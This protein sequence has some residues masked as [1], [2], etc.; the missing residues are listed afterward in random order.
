MMYETYANKKLVELTALNIEKAF[1]QERYPGMTMPLRYETHDIQNLSIELYYD[2]ELD[3]THVRLAHRETPCDYITYAMLKQKAFKFV[4]ASIKGYYPQNKAFIFRDSHLQAA[5]VGLIRAFECMSNDI[6][7][8]ENM[9][10]LIRENYEKMHQL[11]WMHDI[12]DKSKDMW[13]NPANDVLEQRSYLSDFDKAELELEC[14]RA[15][16][17]IRNLNY[18]ELVLYI[19]ELRRRSY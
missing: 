2:D 11:W 1:I 7:F 19:A 10:W 5:L 3:Y 6:Q 18:E 17:V 16:E 13:D 4:K 12:E 9:A 8:Q 14:R 15:N